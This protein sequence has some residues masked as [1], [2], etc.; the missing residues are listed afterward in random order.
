MRPRHDGGAQRAITSDDPFFRGLVERSDYNH[1]SLSRDE[2]GPQN[3]LARIYGI[4]V[5]LAHGVSPLSSPSLISFPLHLS[6]LT[7]QQP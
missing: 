5:A 1:F 7:K 4:V 6:S 3:E 2:A